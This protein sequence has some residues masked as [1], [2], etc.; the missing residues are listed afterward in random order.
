MKNLRINVTKALLFLAFL[1]GW[2][3]LCFSYPEEVT[4]VFES[5]GVILLVLLIAAFALTL[6]FAFIAS[7][8]SAPPPPAASVSRQADPPPPP[9]RQRDT[10]TPLLIGLAL[11]WWLGG[12]PGDGDC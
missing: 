6:V 11:G 4:G 10:L 7:L 9:V 1:A 3:W 8:F 12:G 2:L 5:L